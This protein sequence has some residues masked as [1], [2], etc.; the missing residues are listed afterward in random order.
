[1]KAIVFV[2]FKLLSRVIVLKLS[3][4]KGSL[5]SAGVILSLMV[6][7]NKD[8]SNVNDDARKQWS[9]QLNEEK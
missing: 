9:D 8:D 7:F 5:I 2:S 3:I 1:M 4:D 6:S